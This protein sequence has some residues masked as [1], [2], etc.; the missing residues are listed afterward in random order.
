[1]DTTDAD[2]PVSRRGFLRA[3]GG[4]AAVA[5]ATGTAAAQEGNSSGG[6]ET[7]AVGSGSGLSFDPEELTIAP[8]TTVTWE[9]TGQGGAH[10]VVADDGAFDSGDPEDGD[11]IT[12][13]HTFPE[14][15]EFP[16]HCAPHEEVGMVGTVIVQEGGGS[17]G[18]GGPGL[19]VPNS[20]KNLGIAAM[21]LMLSTLGLAY[22]FIRYG[23][24]YETGPES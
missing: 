18:G 10:N 19:T 2:A 15:G 6:G 20:A 1:M 5:G 7:V 21:S 22:F 8:G 24:D 13:S 4:T 16:Y 17:S 9:W 12:F 14:A 3:A 11:D 23:G